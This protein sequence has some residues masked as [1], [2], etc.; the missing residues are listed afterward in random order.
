[1]RQGRIQGGRSAP[2][3]YE[4]YFFRH[5]FVQFGKQHSRYKA[6]LP[7]IV[8]S[9]QCCEVY[10]IS[11]TLG[12]QNITEIPPLNLLAGPAPAMC[13]LIN[14]KFFH[15]VENAGQSPAGGQCCP[16]PPFE[17]GAPPFHVWPPV[18][19]YIQYSILKMWPPSGFWPPLLL[20]PGDGPEFMEHV[21]PAKLTPILVKLQTNQ[22]YQQELSA[23]VT[24]SW[25][26]WS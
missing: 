18:A 13:K 19:A 17:I 23:A 3:T 8:L 9:Q 22:I 2:K 11:L 6:I 20:N 26:A 4:S 21:A 7:S 12:N 1:M 5:D 25:T 24:R 14:F 15:N 10:F 16:A